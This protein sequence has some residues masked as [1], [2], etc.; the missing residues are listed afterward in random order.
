MGVRVAEF[1]FL[2]KDQTYQHDDTWPRLSPFQGTV[3][4]S[5]YGGKRFNLLF[6]AKEEHAMMPLKQPHGPVILG[7]VNKH[8]ATFKAYPPA[9][10]MQ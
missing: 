10:P 5:L 7:T 3:S 8:L 4:P 2:V 1:K 9:V 6:D